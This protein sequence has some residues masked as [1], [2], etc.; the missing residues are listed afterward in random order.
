MQIGAP[1]EAVNIN[2]APAD[3]QNPE[4]ITDKSRQLFDPRAEPRALRGLDAGEPPPDALDL[5]TV[6][7]TGA[8]APAAPAAAAPTPVTDAGLDE[9]GPTMLLAKEPGLASPVKAAFVED[10]ADGLAQAAA[11]ADSGDGGAMTADEFFDTVKRA[12]G[13]R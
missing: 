6:P 9:A 10:D 7:Q 2:R 1:R 12:F 3:V 4:A 13:A 8:P 11:V 5:S